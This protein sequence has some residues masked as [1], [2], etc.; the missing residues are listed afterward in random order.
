MVKRQRYGKRSARSTKRRRVTR[1]RKRTFKRRKAVIPKAI[2][3]GLFP[4][5]ITRK[6]T[7]LKSFPIDAAAGAAASVEFTPNDMY[8]IDSATA[9]T[10]LPFGWSTMMGYYTNS[11]VTGY[12]VNSTMYNNDAG[13]SKTVCY[14]YHQITDSDE[15]ATAPTV[16]SMED[17]HTFPSVCYRAQRKFDTT[18]R[19]RTKINIAKQFGV[20]KKVLTYVGNGFDQTISTSPTRGSIIKVGVGAVDSTA[21]PS[22]RV[23]VVSLTCYVMFYNPKLNAISQS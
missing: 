6:L 20:N 13:A 23:V 8:N 17:A 9:G 4:P 3:G 1:K 10:D 2:K 18:A 22:V 16:A 11:V 15:S 12:T 7:Y 19:L 21:N 14:L 5:F